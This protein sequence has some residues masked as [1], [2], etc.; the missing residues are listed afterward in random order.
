MN[1]PKRCVAPAVLALLQ[2][3]AIMTRSDGSRAA[4]I[5]V[6][7]CLR[8]WDTSTGYCVSNKVCAQAPGSRLWAC[9]PCAARIEC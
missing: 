7:G 4:S 3:I 6:D 9:T 2:V 1:T 8:L 5:G